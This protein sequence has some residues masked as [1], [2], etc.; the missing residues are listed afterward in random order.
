VTGF[1]SMLT[2]K[3]GCKIDLTHDPSEA[4]QMMAG[5]GL[6]LVKNT[7]DPIEPRRGSQSDIGNSSAETA[8]LEHFDELYRLLDSDESIAQSIYEFLV[9]FPP[10]DQIHEL[11]LRGLSALNELFPK[12][13]PQKTM[14][15]LWS[16]K[17]HLRAQLNAGRLEEDYLLNCVKLLGA[18]ITVL[19]LLTSSLKTPGQRAISFHLASCYQAFLHEH[20]PPS[21]SA[22][23][24]DVE[25]A[26]VIVEELCN[27]LDSLMSVHSSGDAEI[28]E[29]IYTTITEASLHSQLV[30]NA[31]KA[32][33][34]IDEIHQKLILD[35]PDASVR[36]HVASCM[37]VACKSTDSDNIAQADAF[38]SF[39]WEVTSKLI[40][41]ASTM[42]QHSKQLFAAA[43][44]V[45][46]LA[47]RQAPDEAQIRSYLASW[48]ELLSDYIHTEVPGREE[49]D[50]FLFGMINLLTACVMLLK[51]F[52]RSLDAGMLPDT[53]YDRFLFPQIG[54]ESEVNTERLVPVLDFECRTAMHKLV[55][56]L[57]E[58]DTSF[59]RLIGKMKTLAEPK[60]L[61]EIPWN[62]DRTKL[63]RSPAG[64]LG[65]R[66]LTNTCYMNSLLTQ[67]YMNG[68]F[69]SFLLDSNVADA[70]GSQK[71]LGEMQALFA[72]MQGSRGKYADTSKFA[73]AV[74][75]YD[76]Q[77]ID[78]SIQM[79]VDEFFNLLFDRLEGQ[80]LTAEAKQGFRSIFGGQLVTQ[81][82]SKDCIHV[83]ERFE[84]FL[85]VQCDIQGKA[86]LTE[87]LKSYVEG[88]VMEGGTSRSSTFYDFF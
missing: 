32:R 76:A 20:A 49:A 78:V 51:G 21:I 14:Y 79:D 84:P 71:L 25:N 1:K 38:A 41:R 31:F 6:L 80:M 74:V 64:Q 46:T 73:G 61:P 27:G 13:K 4:L 59:E 26:P 54:E 52:K 40:I 67:L 2:I 77:H 7:G 48:A 75:P 53:L 86:N 47:S 24:F 85:A 50:D 44:N 83:S 36:E 9:Q 69:R 66:N 68:G 70:G 15:S 88:D 82:K 63:L 18:S 60:S 5:G 42:P 87:S 11:C 3:D 81:I 8:I 62:S 37:T 56:L 10:H 19:K 29:V 28:V 30:W 33:R 55:V 23:F 16:M 65:L 34:N 43:S 22:Q 39:Y 35:I 57:V 72:H 58:H 45:F 12:G 17:R